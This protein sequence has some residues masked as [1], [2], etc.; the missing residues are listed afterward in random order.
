MYVI[1]VCICAG[2]ATENNVLKCKK[3]NSRKNNIGNF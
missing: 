3:I 2:N 1:D